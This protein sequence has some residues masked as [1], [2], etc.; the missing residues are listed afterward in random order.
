MNETALKLPRGSQLIT[1]PLKNLLG[2]PM[3][4]NLFAS[5]PLSSYL[6]SPIYDA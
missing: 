5:E 2:P 6:I 1:L 4:T 3:P